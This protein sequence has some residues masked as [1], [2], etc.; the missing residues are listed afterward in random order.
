MQDFLAAIEIG[1][2]VAFSRTVTESDI[3]LFAGISGD[4]AR[5]HIDEAYMRGTP[6]GGR[7][8]HGLLL[9]G[10]T[11]RAS[12]LMCEACLKGSDAFVPLALGFDRVRFLRPVRIGETITIRYAI[13]G[14]DVARGRVTSAVTIENEA[15]EAVLAATH[16]VKWVPA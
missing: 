5:N 4:F 8:A 10:Y 7:I 13:E 6:F 15:A 1:A 11:S 14:V 3:S 9:L 12:T 2:T 16:I